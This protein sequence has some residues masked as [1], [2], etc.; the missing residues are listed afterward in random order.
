MLDYKTLCEKVGELAKQTGEWIRQEVGQVAVAQIEFKAMNS[1]VSYVDKTAETRLVKA[2]QEFLPEAGFLT[3]EE[4]VAQDAGSF[5]RWI[6]DPLDGTTN[7]LHQIPFFSVSIALRAGDKTVL[8]VVYEINRQELFSA[9]EGAQSQLNGQLISVSKT[10]ELNHSLLATGFPYHDFSYTE[11][12]GRLLQDLFRSV[13]GLRRLGSAALDLAYVACG[14]FDAF[15]EYSLSA[16]DVA[17]GI[18]IVE[19]AGGVVTGFGESQAHHSGKEI[20]A[21]NPH[22]QPILRNKINQHFD[23]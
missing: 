15:F 19:Q 13:R 14:R 18:F 9:W 3:E 4:T 1:L 16:W 12:Y 17:A 21:G 11:H 7:F 5:Y 6:I 8:G 23:N 2:L 20:V 22:I 10:Q